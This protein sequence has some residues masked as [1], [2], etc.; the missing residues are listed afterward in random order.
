MFKYKLPDSE[1]NL[2]NIDENDIFNILKKDI[3]NTIKTFD[4]YENASYSSVKLNPQYTIRENAFGKDKNL[5]HR[6]IMDIGVKS[7]L[8]YDNFNLFIEPFEIKIAPSKYGEQPRENANLTQS[9][10]DFMVK[11]FP[12]SEYIKKREEYFDKGNICQ[13]IEDDLLL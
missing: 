8:T 10:L 4:G 7:Y 12:D 3:V 2:R 6:I 13:K 1:F 11:Q 9:F 5:Y